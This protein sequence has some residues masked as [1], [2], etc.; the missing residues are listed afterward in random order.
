MRTQQLSLVRFIGVVIVLTLSALVP[1][2]LA[3][4]SGVPPASYVA[5]VTLAD[6]PPDFPPE[7]A[8]ILVGVW[9]TDF[10][11]DGVYNVTRNGE[12]VA[13]GTYTSNK[14]YL[15]VRDKGGP[16]A[17]LDASGIATGIYTW[18]LDNNELTLTPVLDRCF[19]RQFVLTLHPMP[20]L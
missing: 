9:I 5:T 1:A 6:I 12:F 14:S 20:Q 11:A 16:L 7:Y 10:T 2:A 17:C 13:N 15:V 19:G 18:T 8:E 4:S 3:A